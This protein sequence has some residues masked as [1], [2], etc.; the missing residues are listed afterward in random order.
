[1]VS[2]TTARPIRP[3]E[4]LPGDDDA[5]LVAMVVLGNE[6]A[7]GVLFDRHAGAVG[8]VGASILRGS[9]AV[10]DLIQE[11]F[12]AV[13][14][15]AD[16]YEA[17][18]GP[19][20]TWLLTIARRKAIDGLRTQ[21]RR[22]RLAEASGAV[23]RLAASPPGPLAQVIAEDEKRRIRAALAHLPSAQRRALL[24]AYWGGL[25]QEQVSHRSGVPVG[26]VKS[27]IRL[28]QKK[29]ARGFEPTPRVPSGL[30]RGRRAR[31]TEVIADPTAMRSAS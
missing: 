16:R 2:R 10:D 26:T 24:L 9:E 29:I 30:P 19:V 20:T 11:T 5:A 21:V 25:T 22:A 13:W 3:G 31:A 23:A 28:G 27:R 18:Q 1:L 12:L 15:H 7:L 14:R 8:R 4:D 17:V 6:H